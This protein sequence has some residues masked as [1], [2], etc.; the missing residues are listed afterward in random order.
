M[1]LTRGAVFIRKQMVHYSCFTFTFA[2]AQS[3]SLPVTSLPLTT[4]MSYIPDPSIKPAKQASAL[5]SPSTFF[6]SASSPVVS[7]ASQ[8]S[9]SESNHLSSRLNSHRSAGVCQL[10][11]P[12]VSLTHSGSEQGGEFTLLMNLPHRALRQNLVFYHFMQFAVLMF[13]IVIFSLLYSLS[14]QDAHRAAPGCLVSVNKQQS[15]M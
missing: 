12:K 15:A 3:S 6:Y 7:Q 2:P 4:P 11:V 14:L 13:M 8:S 1:L 5:P 10:R 9:E